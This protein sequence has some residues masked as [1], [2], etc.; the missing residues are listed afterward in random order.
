MSNPKFT[1]LIPTRDR[2]ETLHSTITSCLA[3]DYDNFRVIVSDNVSTDATAEVVASFNDPRLS[4]VQPDRRLSMTGNFEFSL[5]HV[6]D[7]FV[8]HLGDDDGLL[9]GGVAVAAAVA[10]ETGCEAVTSSHSVYHWPNSLF[11]SHRNTL[12]LQVA[13]GYEMRD[14]RVYNQRVANYVLNYPN[15]PGTYVSFVDVAVIE[16]AKCAGKYYRSI[17]PDC[18]SG[19][20]NAAHLD[21]YAYSKRPFAMSGISGRSNGA[22]QIVAT[23]PKEADKYQAENDIQIHPSVVYCPRSV[24]IVVAEAFLQAREQASALLDVDFDLTHLCHVALRDASETNYAAVREAVEQISR[25]NGLGLAV[26]QRKSTSM[27]M[28]AWLFKNRMR[29]ERLSQGYR[30]ID[31]APLGAK[32]INDACRIAANRLDHIEPLL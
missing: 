31:C 3:Q 1:V 11:E 30:R 10:R 2:C 14:A 5:S 4:M 8:M 32:T 27:M 25:I 21:R 20:L 29:L 15:L 22:S 19:F 7:G 24:E 16:R 28:R 23:D 18:Y 17:T 26:P 12:T 6:T 13:K 9:P